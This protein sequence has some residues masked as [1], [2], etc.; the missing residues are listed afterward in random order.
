MEAKAHYLSLIIQCCF[1]I[2]LTLIEL[3]F[4]PEIK[5]SVTGKG[6]FMKY[7]A[8]RPLGKFIKD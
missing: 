1:S 6:R 8:S 5:E 7:I 4:W 2:P 3:S